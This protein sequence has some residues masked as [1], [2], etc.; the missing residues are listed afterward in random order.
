MTTIYA[1]GR[2]QLPFTS[3]NISV[4]GT[5]GSLGVSGTFYLSI[6]GQNRVG[7]NLNSALV[8]VTVTSTSIVQITLP[9][10]LTGED[11][12]FIVISGSA[13]NEAS[14]LTQIMS[15]PASAFTSTINLS[16]ANIFQ[17]SLSQRTVATPSNL[18][19][20]PE[21]GLIRYV[22]STNYYYVFS[23]TSTAT[24]DG[25]TV[26]S[27]SSGAWLR[28]GS[29]STY[30]TDMTADGGCNQDVRSPNLSPIT[31]SYACDGSKGSPVT[32][33][34]LNDYG[35]AVPSGT[36]VSCMVMMQGEDRSA[37]FANKLILEMTGYMDTTSI[38]LDTSE[39]SGEVVFDPYTQWLTLPD[40]LE[41]GIAAVVEVS[42]EFTVADLAGLIPFG[43]SI[44]TYLSFQTTAGVYA[45]GCFG[46]IIYPSGNKWHIINGTGL[47]VTKL[48]GSGIVQNYELLDTPDYTI[49]GL[50]ANTSGQYIF[51]SNTGSGFASTTSTNA[52]AVIRAQVS[53]VNGIANATNSQSISLSSTVQLSVT[54]NYPTQINPAYPDECAGIT[55][56]DFNATSVVLFLKNS[57][58]AVFSCTKTCTPNASSDTFQVDWSAFSSSTLPSQPENFGLYV[59]VSV[60]STTVTTT[61]TFP[62]GTY[63][64]SV[65]FQYTNVVTSI[66][67]SVSQLEESSITLAEL[68]SATGSWAS[69]L[70]TVEQMRALDLG[71]VENYQFRFLYATGYA[72]YFDPANTAT[73]DGVNVIKLTASGTSAG[74]FVAYRGSQWNSGDS[75]PVSTFGNNGDFFFNTTTD[76]IFEKVSGSWTNLGSIAGDSATVSLGT[77]TPLNPNA[78]PTVTNTGTSSSE[79]I[80]NFGL[81]A[82]PTFTIGTVTSLSSGSNPTATNTGT[83]G[84][85][86]LNLGIPAGATGST[87]AQGQAF[88]NT[89]ANFTQPGVGYQVNVSL[90]YIAWMTAGQIIFIS[91]GGY[92]SVISVPSSSSYAVTIEN[93]GGSSNSSVGSTINSGAFVTPAGYQG[94]AAF[95]TTTSAFSMPSVG[96]NVNIGVLNT[97]WLVAGLTIFVNSAGYFQ[98]A[99]VESSTVI[100]I[101]NIGSSANAS[102][103]TTISTGQ[104]VGISSVI[105]NLTIGTVTGLSAGSSPTV[106]NTGT[107]GAAILNFGLPAGANGTTPTITIGTVTSLSSGSTPTVSNTGTSTAAVFNFGIPAGASGTNGTNGTNGSAATITIGSVNSLSAG[108]TPTVTNT[109]SSSAAV[110]NF[111]IPVGATGATG[112]T[113]ATGASAFTTTSA[114]FTM[115]A[116]SSTVSVTVGSTAWMS[117][118]QTLF[119]SNAGYFTIISITSNTVVVLNNTGVSTNSTSGSTI[120]SGQ[121]VSGAGATGPSGSIGSTGSAGQNSFTT[122]TSGFTMPASSANVS[123][124][125]G[126]T[127]WMVVGQ[128][129]FVGTAGYFSVSSITS[130]TVV[131][132]TN[133]GA[134]GNAASTTA[135]ASGVGVSPGGVIGATGSVSSASSLIFTEQSS[136]PSSPSSGN[137]TLYSK[138]TDQLLHIVNSSGTDKVIATTST[139]QQFSGTQGGTINL[140]TFSSTPV[141]DLS[142]NNFISIT[143]TGNI[144]SLSFT[145]L[146]VGTFVFWFIQDTIGS[147]TVTW[148]SSIFKFANKTQPTLSTAA[149]SIDILTFVCD[150]T[151]LYSVLTPNLG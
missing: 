44:E 2:S 15:V 95:T 18:P 104:Y 71:N 140:I 50:A 98:I 26:L 23:S 139:A 64:L 38:T 84:N 10:I 17:L 62:T 35:N 12:Q 131:V 110:F 66:D 88:T 76:N 90:G 132:L 96:N 93:L 13:T 29:I 85:I 77:V 58:G 21:N 91:G 124:T 116:A 28:I 9:T 109:G 48:D 30:L 92:Y 126:S 129:V 83:N 3:S 25:L 60:N 114:S 72:Y 55:T 40:D 42:P 74:A 27:A 14:V 24:A 118:G 103:G 7:L 4:V 119:V 123:V 20:N 149:N 117:V 100:Q 52:N 111:G 133:N 146:R 67:H 57:S 105:P 115:P 8:P 45:P 51:L 107:N 31:P 53:T 134:S 36:R 81:P 32:F 54:I 6:Q 128:T 138:T 121:N 63:T 16:S 69:A 113:G 73:D 46:N 1:S 37:L 39:A 56:N 127:S 125:V 47:S 148:S 49:N 59:P 68:I 5:G 41:V 143:L 61:S 130:S 22:T 112:S 102:A 142:A 75:N 101:T 151:Y 87:G 78:T 43:S 65:A 80:F 135:I 33:W 89:T 86:I 144:S 147:R 137:L 122:V 79:A 99:A 34:L 106:T 150:G 136:T 70:N 108:A 145:N 97:A 19:A 141:V 94:Q 120:A 11:W 82:A